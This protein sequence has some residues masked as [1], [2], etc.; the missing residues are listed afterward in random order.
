VVRVAIARHDLLAA[1]SLVAVAVDR[2]E[3]VGTVLSRSPDDLRAVL[4]PH[5]LQR[6]HLLQYVAWAERER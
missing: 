1:D 6:Y 4:P 5:A 3:V 2:G